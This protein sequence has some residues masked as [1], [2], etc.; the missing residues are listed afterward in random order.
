MRAIL[1]RP[2]VRLLFGGQFLSMFGDW[3]M[4][5]AL[6]VWARVLTGSNAEAGLVFLFLG[7]TG[8]IAPLGGIVVDR[9]PKRRLMIWTHLALAGVMCLLLLVHSRSDLWL[10]YAVT[11]LYGLGGDVFAASRTSMLKAMLPDEQLGEANGVLQTMRE[12]LRIVAPVTGAGLFAAFDGHVVA[13]TDAATF[14]GSAAT[15]IALPFVEP[16]IAPR[17]HRFLREASA[18]VAHIVRTK[19]LRELTIGLCAALAVIGFCETLIFAIVIDGLGLSA[20]WVG[21][22]DMFQ[23]I[24]AI[25]GG[26]TAAWLMRR[27]G[28][29]RLTGVGLGL[30]AIASFGFLIPSLGGVLP[31]VVVFGAGIAWVIIAALTAYQRRSPQEIQGRV[32]AATNMLFSVPQTMSIALGA[33]LITLIPY[34]I[35]IVVMGVVTLAAAAYLFTREAEPVTET[36]VES[37]LAA[38]PETEASAIV[39]M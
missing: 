28:D 35:E 22:I 14:V 25:A 11:F 6:G 26:L 24:G 5:I 34:R 30:F 27:L 10:I 29:V 2:D 31:S 18:G 19:V 23:G 16:P 38:L 7:V 17:E 32:S 13:V 15:L 3:A 8:L 12:G 1:R 36:E 33:A 4:F 21:F 39:E 20:P 37:V 9:L